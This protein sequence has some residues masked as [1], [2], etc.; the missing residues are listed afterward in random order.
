[1]GS[2]VLDKLK[3]LWEQ[4]G[5]RLME[6]RS[7]AEYV[8]LAFSTTPHVSPVLL[9]S[10]A[11]GRLQH[12]LKAEGA[13]AGFSR[14]VSVRS[15]GENTRQQVEQYIA[16]QVRHGQFADPRF[17]DLLE[18]F[19]VRCPNVDLS[20]ETNASGEYELW[21]T[22]EVKGAAVGKHTVRI[23]KIQDPEQEGGEPPVVIP[24]RYST[25]SNLTAEVKAGGIP[26]TSTWSP[27]KVG[28]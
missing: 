7:S 12:A 21:Y 16:S 23:E 17:R 4:D 27:R 2:D 24:D 19:T 10:R 13:F 20:C 5:L 3:P 11:K 28:R 15:V 14:M 26:S 6:H 25:D 22:N 9:A 18:E 8:Q 1:M